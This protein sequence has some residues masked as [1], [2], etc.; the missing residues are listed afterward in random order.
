[1]GIQVIFDREAALK[2][3]A[4][5]TELFAYEFVGETE[6]GDPIYEPLFI[7]ELS[8]PETGLVTSN[9]G[10]GQS[11]IQ[12]DFNHWGSI[13]PRLLPWL[14]KHNISFRQV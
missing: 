3:G 2:A 6:N 10:S 8:I 4:I 7:S 1:M 11:E 12:T 9:Y 13:R 14:E 5:I